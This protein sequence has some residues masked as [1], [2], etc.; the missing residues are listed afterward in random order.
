[1]GCTRPAQHHSHPSSLPEA[2]KDS[3]P[4]VQ[5]CQPHRSLQPTGVPNRTFELGQEMGRRGGAGC[6]GQ[7]WPPWLTGASGQSEKGSALGHQ[8]FRVGH[9]PPGGYPG[10]S[11]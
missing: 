5:I 11:N 2:P 10:A 9:V 1:M 8:V 7:S 6:G 3:Q 4:R